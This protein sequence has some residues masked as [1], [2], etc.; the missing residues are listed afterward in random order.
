M[1]TRFSIGSERKTMVFALFRMKIDSIKTG[2]CLQR[3][4]NQNWFC[5]KY[6]FVCYINAITRDPMNYGI[7]SKVWN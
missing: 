7:K 6:H 4:N 5:Y 1:S 2:I 3:E